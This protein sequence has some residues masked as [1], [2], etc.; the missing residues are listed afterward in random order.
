MNSVE[1]RG[2]KEREEEKKRD[3]E[4]KEVRGRRSEMSPLPPI[5]TSGPA[6]R[7]CMSFAVS[8]DVVHN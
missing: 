8:S 6:S 2:R 5:P 1:I 3:K 4:E 7:C